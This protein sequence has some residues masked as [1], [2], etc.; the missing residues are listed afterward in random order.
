MEKIIKQKILSK[1]WRGLFCFE[2][3]GNLF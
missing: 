3:I 1:H 2:K